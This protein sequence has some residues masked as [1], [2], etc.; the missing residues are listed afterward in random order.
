MKRIAFLLLL[1]L[2]GTSLVA[3][4]IHISQMERVTFYF[5]P[6]QTGFMKEKMR[7]SSNVKSQWSSVT[8]PFNEYLLAG[9]MNFKP[10]KRSK[11]K[12]G[13]GISLMYEKAGD[14]KLQTFSSGPALSYF[15]PVGLFK[16]SYVSLG[17]STEINQKSISYDALNFDNQFNGWYF[18][19]TLPMGENFTYKNF[20][21]LTISTGVSYMYY[22]SK[23][24]FFQAGLGIKNLNTPS[25]SWL[26]DKN[27]QLKP[28]STFSF[29][30]QKSSIYGFYVKPF[31][32]VSFQSTQSEW[33]PGV[34]FVWLKNDEKSTYQAL[35]TGL[36]WRV[37]DGIVWSG[38]YDFLNYRFG[39]S[40]DVNL[41]KL[42]KASYGRGGFEVSFIY[43]HSP[44]EARA[45]QIVCP[46][47]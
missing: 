4:D 12:L 34:L 25:V 18:D 14:S 47:F 21:Y 24:E 37:K 13:L 15:F 22:M 26:S 8:V 9:E 44:H 16:K 7:F 3:Q 19:P 42:M 17:L 46:I 41:S 20:L 33:L 39:V 45:N 2:V 29:L 43:L 11:S 23:N 27:V 35:S 31:V 40:Y 38:Y 36:T 10:Y 28:R 5:N 1:I 30:L 32:F 6:A